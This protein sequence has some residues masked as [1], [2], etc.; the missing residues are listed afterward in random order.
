MPVDFIFDYIDVH[1]HSPLSE[2]GPKPLRLGG[3][4]L[5]GILK[6]VLARSEWPHAIAVNLRHH[7]PVARRGLFE[8]V[9][10]EG[11]LRVSLVD[12]LLSHILQK[13]AIGI[14]QKSAGKIC[15]ARESR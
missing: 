13:L 12:D 15:D 6:R 14:V 7:P 4:Y 5:E 2:E 1:R 9:S 8:A 11:H 10:P 3:V